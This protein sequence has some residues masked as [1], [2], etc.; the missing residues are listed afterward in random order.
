MPRV[1]EFQA[2]SCVVFVLSLLALYSQAIF[3]RIRAPEDTDELLNVEIEKR[4]N[5]PMIIENPFFIVSEKMHS[6]I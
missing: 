5:L 6:V 3:N 2:L 4:H 1:L